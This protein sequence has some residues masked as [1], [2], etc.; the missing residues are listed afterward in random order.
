MEEKI[1]EK[2]EEKLNDKMTEL[3][4]RMDLLAYENE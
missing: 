1:V 2:L 4:H 3:N